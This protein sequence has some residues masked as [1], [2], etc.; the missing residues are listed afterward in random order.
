M[1]IMIFLDLRTV[2]RLYG[3]GYNYGIVYADD[4]ARM[5]LT[6]QPYIEEEVVKDFRTSW[7]RGDALDKEYPVYHTLSTPASIHGTGYEDFEIIDLK[8][9][10]QS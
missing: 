10:L 1:A 7:D 6:T 8:E 9:F 2:A 3:D 4:P 5:Y